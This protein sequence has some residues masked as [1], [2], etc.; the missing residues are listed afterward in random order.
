MSRKDQIISLLKESP[1]DS[2]LLFALAKEHEKEGAD[3]GAREV[4]ERLVRDFPKD[5]GTYY[6][7]GKLLEKMGDPAAAN[8]VY[9]QGIELTRTI[10]EQHAMRELMGAR[11]ELGFDEEE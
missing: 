6:H 3:A 5:P 2:F 11:M 10:G 8:K 4:Y 9:N 1:N 7:L